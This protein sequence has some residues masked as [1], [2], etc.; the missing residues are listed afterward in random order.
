[1]PFQ[2]ITRGVM[3]YA[4]WKISKTVN[5]SSIFLELNI[6]HEGLLKDSFQQELTLRYLKGFVEIDKYFQR[7]EVCERLK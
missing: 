2:S 3:S 6:N 4:V 7:S 1:M 5:G